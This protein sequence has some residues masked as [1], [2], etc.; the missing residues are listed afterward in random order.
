MEKFTD[1]PTTNLAPKY[2]NLSLDPDLKYISRS[3][4]VVLRESG[5]LDTDVSVAAICG[6]DG[7]SEGI[8]AIEN[9]AIDGKIIVYPACKGLELTELAKLKEEMPEVAE[10][11][12]DGTWNKK[13]EEVLLRAYGKS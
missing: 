3:Y 6:L 12:S 2:P 9:R 10:C 4:S 11:L 13:A 8:R 7:A 5:R 1:T